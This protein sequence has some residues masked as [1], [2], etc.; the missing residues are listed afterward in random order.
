MR[1]LIGK[2]GNL[3]R[4]IS[5]VFIY[6][7]LSFRAAALAYTTLLGLV[8]LMI[9]GF[10]MLSFFPVFHGVGIRIQELVLQNFTTT[11]APVI[12]KYLDDFAQ[13]VSFL[14]IRNIFFLILIALLMI[15]EINRAFNSVWHAERHFHFSLS[16]LTYFIVLVLSPILLGG[17]M[18][19]GTFFI[20][21]PFVTHIIQKSYVQRPLFFL[22]PYVLIF[23][24][25]TLFNW[26]LPSCR[27]KLFAAAVGGLVTTILFEL[28][29]FLFTWY[30]R[31]FPTYQLIYGALA[32]IPIFLVW[33]YV[34]WTVILLGA[35]ISYIT[36][37]GIPPKAT[38]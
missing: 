27:V 12:V 10:T 18:V 19:L 35:I 1:Q 2:L 24:L 30:L 20:K 33:L 13:H 32:T 17:V 11:S 21:I 9:I 6:D 16:F 15:F 22:L 7:G 23:L 31:N 14:S 26:V 28:A 37:R 5:H 25:F 4:Y 38:W 8:P 3:L 36:A 34:S 29:K